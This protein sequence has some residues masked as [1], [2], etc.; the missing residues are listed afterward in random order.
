M[1]VDQLLAV[2]DTVVEAGFGVLPSGVHELIEAIAPLP[3][4]VVTVTLKKETLPGDPDARTDPE[5]WAEQR[6]RAFKQRTST[7]PVEAEPHQSPSEAAPVAPDRASDAPD[8]QA[9]I[10]AR[11]YGQPT[12]SGVEVAQKFAASIEVPD[13]VRALA[14]ECGLVIVPSHRGVEARRADVLE[15]CTANIEGMRNVLMALRMRELER[16]MK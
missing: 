12:P 2:R 15:F 7:A 16:M 13:D 4:G 1:K 11:K 5:A 8:V 9:L 3:P 14:N 6:R 10:A